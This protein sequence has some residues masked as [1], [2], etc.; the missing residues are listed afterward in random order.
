MI[1]RP[2]DLEKDALAILDGAKDFATR[3]PMNH[4]L[5][6]D[7][8]TDAVARIVTLPDFELTLAEHNDVVVA[9]IGIFYSAF[10]WNPEILVAEEHF[11]WADKDAPYSAGFKVIKQAIKNIEER[12]AIP[13]FKSLTTSHKGVDKVYRSLGMKPVET[14]YMRVK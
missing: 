5:Q 7:S 2:A 10:I 14:L 13:M 6:G 11:W 12:G 3:T 1:I 4:L 8:Y 9:G